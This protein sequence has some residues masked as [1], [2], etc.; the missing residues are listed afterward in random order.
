MST[1]LK[2][3]QKSIFEYIE[4]SALHPKLHVLP[5]G[6]IP[7]NPIQLLRRESFGP[8]LEELKEVYDYVIVDTAPSMI[9]ADTFL[10]GRYADMT[11]YLIRAGKSKKKVL[12]FVLE[13][14]AE[15][16]LINPIFLLNDV[17]LADAAYGYKY[18]YKYGMQSE[19]SKWAALSDRIKSIFTRS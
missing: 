14:T 3:G 11:L 4:N 2:H 8:M 5:S 12:E 1:Y 9:L 17:N 16:K 10:I 7:N 6:P 18:G 15:G 13:S 19:T